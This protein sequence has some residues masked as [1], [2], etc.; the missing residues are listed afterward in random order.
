MPA[1][2]QKNVRT[3]RKRGSNKE[4]GQPMPAT[5]IYIASATKNT[6]VLTL[7]FNQVVSLNADLV[8]QIT[9]SVAGATPVSVQQTAPNTVAI[10]YSASIAAATSLTIPFRDPAIRGQ[11]G[12]FVT[13]STFPVS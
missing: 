12:G 9:T 5:P 1:L 7:V 6:T 10:T 2:S 11:S 8:P 13:S 3:S 4:A